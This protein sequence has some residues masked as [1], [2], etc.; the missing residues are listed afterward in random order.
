MLSSEFRWHSK[1]LYSLKCCKDGK[2]AN[3]DRLVEYNYSVLNAG[4]IQLHMVAQV[5]LDNK[6]QYMFFRDVELTGLAERPMK[7]V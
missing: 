5:V 6:P 4:Q 3:I 2:C 7:E 1:K